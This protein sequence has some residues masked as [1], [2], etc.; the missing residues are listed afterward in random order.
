MFQSLVVLA[1]IR[2]CN[3]L[4]MC[5]RLRHVRT[6][7]TYIHIQYISCVSFE[8]LTE[9]YT[10]PCMYVRIQVFAIYIPHV[11]IKK[12]P[13]HT[14]VP[15]FFGKDFLAFSFYQETRFREE[16]NFFFF[17]II[18]LTRISSRESYATR[19][20]QRWNDLQQRNLGVILTRFKL[21]WQISVLTLLLK[22]ANDELTCSRL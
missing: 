15:W 7:L 18:E 11:I 13:T 16:F 20:Q 21:H 2:N 6:V 1:L 17:F 10:Y 22:D 9:S 19:R 3:Y 12:S 14:Q 8:K 5:W 4:R